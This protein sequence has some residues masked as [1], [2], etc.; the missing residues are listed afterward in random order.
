MLFRRDASTGVTPDCAGKQPFAITGDKRFVHHNTIGNAPRL[1]PDQLVGIGILTYTHP[2]AAASV[3]K[4]V[5]LCICH[6]QPP[7]WIK[8]K[9]GVVDAAFWVGV[10]HYCGTGT[11]GTT[12]V[13]A[14]AQHHN[15]PPNLCI[16]TAVK[17]DKDASFWADFNGRNSLPTAVCIL[18]PF[19]R[20]IDV[21][22]G[23]S[24]RRLIFHVANLFSYDFIAHHE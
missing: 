18:K 9:V 22:V 6:P 20:R 10:F 23:R 13:I 17:I 12:V 21:N 19:L 2:Y 24:K 16:L 11:E 14:D 8:P 3:I 4:A 7:Q 5:S 15:I 1:G